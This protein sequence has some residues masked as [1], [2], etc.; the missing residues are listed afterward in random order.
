MMLFLTILL[1]KNAANKE[2]AEKETSG[3]KNYNNDEKESKKEDFQ[4]NFHINY[5]NRLS[6]IDS[7]NVDFSL[8][9]TI[10]QNIKKDKFIFFVS[11]L[12]LLVICIL[13][14]KS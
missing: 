4:Q 6:I 10:V 1:K 7:E 2:T 11:L 12:S 9:N 14:K 5:K 8:K 3:K 13:I